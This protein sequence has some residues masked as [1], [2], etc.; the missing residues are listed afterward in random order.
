MDIERPLPRGELNFTHSKGVSI[1]NLK[2]R[3]WEVREHDRCD[4]KMS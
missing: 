2:L 3:K 1:L 4:L